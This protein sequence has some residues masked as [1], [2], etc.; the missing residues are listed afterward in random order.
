[1]PLLVNVL[2]YSFH[3]HCV[4]PLKKALSPEEKQYYEREADKQN[5]MNPIE[6]DEEDEDDDK[7]IPEY[8][9]HVQ[10]DMQYAVHPGMG[11]PGMPQHDPRQHAYAPYPTHHMAYGQ[12]PYQGQ[13]YAAQGDARYHQGRAHGYQGYPPARHPYDNSGMGM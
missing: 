8:M 12:A 7:R 6:K 10:P 1:M 3:F 4:F 11:Q 9:H 5:G 2:T 13:H